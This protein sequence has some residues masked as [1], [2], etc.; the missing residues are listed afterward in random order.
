MWLAVIVS[1][2]LR[3]LWG[4]PLGAAS[5]VPDFPAV[6]VIGTETRGFV[7]RIEVGLGAGGRLAAVKR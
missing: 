1:L 4:T 5:R 6:A 3:T 7:F 2:P